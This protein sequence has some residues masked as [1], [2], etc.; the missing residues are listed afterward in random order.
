[1]KRKVL[2]A[3][4]DKDIVQ[5]I[6]LYIENENIEVLV[7][8][9]GQEA[10]DIIET[11][12]I[13]LVVSDI[14]MP[15][16]NGFEL[17]KKVRENLKIPIIVISAKDQSADKVLGLNIGA[18]DYITKPFDPLEVVARVQAQLRRNY[19]FKE[20]SGLNNILKVRELELDIDKVALTKNDGIINLT[21]T[22]FK[23][24]KLL[25]THPGMIYTKAQIYE[26]VAGDFFESDENTLMV[27]I[28]NLRN[29]IEDDPKNPTYIKTIRGLG[30]KIEK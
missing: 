30:Y 3:E 25:M 16:M 20:N 15:L 12:Q 24:L 27:H 28:S 22:E 8:Q 19:Q 29:K 13:D 11:E 21:A 23:I 17:I 18:D 6:K 5:I 2:I 7:A 1:M 4:D 10:M 26:H 9:N 14:M